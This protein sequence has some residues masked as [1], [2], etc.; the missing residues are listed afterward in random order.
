MK[1][2]EVTIL[3]AILAFE[4]GV[5]VGVL[6]HRFMQPADSHVEWMRQLEKTPRLEWQQ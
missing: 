1:S 2:T 5:V 3:V 6:A 4:I